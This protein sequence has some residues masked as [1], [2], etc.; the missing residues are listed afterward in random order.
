MQLYFRLFFPRV[1]AMDF[2]LANIFVC[3]QFTYFD[4]RNMNELNLAAILFVNSECHPHKH[5]RVCS[6][7]RRHRTNNL[8]DQPKQAG[9]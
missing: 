9:Y 6:R 4:F 8:S 3:G 7:V 1:A 2:F 5:S